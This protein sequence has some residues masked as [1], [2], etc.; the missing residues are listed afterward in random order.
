MTPE[1]RK[2]LR[3][4]HLASLPAC[5]EAARRDNTSAIATRLRD[6]ANFLES[7]AGRNLSAANYRSALRRIVI[8]EILHDEHD[9]KGDAAYVIGASIQT[10]VGQMENRDPDNKLLDRIEAASIVGGTAKLRKSK[11]AMLTTVEA[12]A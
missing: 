3:E 8:N 12:A 10:F 1:E 11:R 6:I 4:E 9:D 5:R 2:I 7:E